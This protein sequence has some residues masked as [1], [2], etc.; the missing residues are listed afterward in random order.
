MNWSIVVP[1][2]AGDDAHRVR[3]WGWLY[4]RIRALFP[5]AELIVAD[6]DP[7]LPFS[8]AQAFNLG[9]QR[10][11]GERIVLFDAD[12]T[13]NETFVREALEQPGW[14]LASLYRQM[15]MDVTL[16]VLDGPV[17]VDIPDTVAADWEGGGSWAGFMAIDRADYLDV[18]GYDERLDGWAP[19]DIG[20]AMTLITMVGQPV[21]MGGWVSHFNHDT[22]FFRDHGWN[23]TKHELMH[24]YL[25]AVGDKEAIRRIRG[26]A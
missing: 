5:D 15:T 20:I 3:T 7:A 11:A 24:A 8:H 2:R 25:A 19:D 9:V 13:C 23:D 14:V 18:G 1:F 6:S 17:D 12:T 26:Q 4:E 10:A 22:A 21:R 16:S